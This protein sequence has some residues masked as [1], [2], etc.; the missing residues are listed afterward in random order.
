M[1]DLSLAIETGDLLAVIGPNGAGKSTLLRMLA[2]TLAP[3]RG[4]VRLLGRPIAGRERREIARDVAVVMQSEEVR[5]QFSVQDV[6]MMGRAP[7]QRGAM[8]PSTEDMKAVEEALVRCDLEGLATRPVDELSGGEKKRVAIARAFAQSAPVMLLDEPTAFLD[9]RHQVALFEQLGEL[10]VNGTT[11]V[12]VT[13]DLQLAAA[14]ATRV[15]LMKAGRLVAYGTVDEVLAG[16]GLEEAFDCPI[17]VG[18]LDGT[19]ARVFVPRRQARD[20]P[21]SPSGVI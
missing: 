3:V 19:G 9:V 18:R 2:G 5:F 11:S 13:H 17:D 16:P 21:G 1:V 4:E 15:A 7:H 20:E 12:V 8:R 6:V 14:H 10:R